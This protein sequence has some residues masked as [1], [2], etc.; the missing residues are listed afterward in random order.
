MTPVKAFS[1]NPG[2]LQSGI[3]TQF[4]HAISPCSRLIVPPGFSDARNISDLELP[5]LPLSLS[6]DEGKEE[7]SLGRE[8]KRMAGA[9]VSLISRQSFSQWK[10]E[11]RRTW[12]CQRFPRRGRQCGFV[13]FKA[14]GK[15]KKGRKNCEFFSN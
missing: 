10:R 5:T 6:L 9:P 14:E 12:S 15:R 11:E 3:P 2:I 13:L 1:S 8:K 7:G 4:L